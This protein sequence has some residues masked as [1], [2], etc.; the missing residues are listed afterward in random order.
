MRRAQRKITTS[1][2]IVASSQ[3]WRLLPT[4]F[5]EPNTTPTHTS[6]NKHQSGTDLGLTWVEGRTDGGTAWIGEAEAQ[7]TGQSG[8]S[9]RSRVLALRARNCDSRGTQ[10]AKYGFNEEYGLN[11]I[12]IRYLI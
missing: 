11:Y 7:A 5:I 3:K 12:G 6:P 1:A 10:G 9:S 2:H 8:S 4:F